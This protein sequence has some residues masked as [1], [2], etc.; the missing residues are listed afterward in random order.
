MVTIKDVAAK[1]GVNASTV[2][3][4]LKNSSSISEKTK[5]KVRRA[6]EELGYV[7]NVTA[8]RLASGLTKAIGLIL[9]PMTTPDRISQPFF[10]EILAAVNDEARQHDLTLSIATGTSLDDLYNQV[11]LMYKQKLVDGFII[12]YSEKGDP[13]SQYLRSNQIP[14]VIVGQAEELMNEVTF[15]DND[16]QLMARTAVDYLHQKGHRNILFVTDDQRSEVYLER[17]FGYVRGT[18]SLNLPIFDS[19]VFDRHDAETLDHLIETIKSNQITAAVVID[20]MLAVRFMQFL[21]FYGINVPHDISIISFNN[22]TYSRIVH[23]YLTSFDINIETLGRTSLQRLL[24]K[25]KNSDVKAEKIIVPF[26]LKE[27]E[28]V[29]R[30]N[31]GDDN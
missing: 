1:A 24:E 26:D 14:F 28:S 8:A 21:S 29:R 27:R 9:P 13:V 5:E 15:I 7:P 31:G 2:S 16:N 23:P 4:T 11:V 10:M 20:D 30:L 19:G 6:M 18:S 3:R 12:L 22:S 17:Y 25:I